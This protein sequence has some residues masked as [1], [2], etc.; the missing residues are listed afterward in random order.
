[1]SA[2]AFR[3]PQ[4]FRIR[5][6]LLAPVLAATL[7]AAPDPAAATGNLFDACRANIHA[8]VQTKVNLLNR[9][10]Q[11]RMSMLRQKNLH[12]ASA[13]VHTVP[14]PF[15]CVAL[16]LHYKHGGARRGARTRGTPSPSGTRPSMACAAKCRAD[17]PDLPRGG[18]PL[19]G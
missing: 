5:R 11:S 4:M 8:L 19:Y 14:N 10:P 7:V 16:I 17:G 9:A 18:I 6:L 12:L 3:E 1:M 13:R 2:T 15:A